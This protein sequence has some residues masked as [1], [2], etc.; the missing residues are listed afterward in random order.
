MLCAM[1]N[2]LICAAIL[3]CLVLFLGIDVLQQPAAFLETATVLLRVSLQIPINNALPL[4]QSPQIYSFCTDASR[5][6]KKFYKKLQRPL[7][8]APV[9][10]PHTPPLLF[11]DTI[12]LSLHTAS[13][14]TPS[15]PSSSVLISNIPHLTL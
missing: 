12:I 15:L 1:C 6:Y 13:P 5:I 3:S 11:L 10:N 14:H 9:R 2:Y 4:V 8:P 7:Q